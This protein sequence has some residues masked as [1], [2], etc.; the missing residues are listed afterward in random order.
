MYIIKEVKHVL[1]RVSTTHVLSI[2]SLILRPFGVYIA[3]TD[4]NHLHLNINT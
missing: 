4:C 3:H 1:T 2:V